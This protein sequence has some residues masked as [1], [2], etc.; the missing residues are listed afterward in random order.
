MAPINFT[1]N[2]AILFV[3]LTYSSMDLFVEWERFSLCYRPIQLW[4]IV[5]FVAIIAFR[6]SHYLG[7][8]LSDDGEEFLIY[9]QR[10]P[11]YWV[12]VLILGVLFPFFTAWTIVGT[13][14]FNQLQEHTPECLPQGSHPW[15]LMFWLVLCYI[16]IAI[17]VIFIALAM[18]Y[19][20]RARRIE[21][22]LR[23]IE[24]EDILR[25]WGRLQVLAD[26]GI[27][28]VKRGLSPT[29]IEKLPYETLDKD[30]PEQPCSICIEDFH[31]GDD[32]RLLGGCGHLFH[33]SCIDI[34]L[35]RN[36]VCP[37]CKSPIGAVGCPS[38]AIDDDL[39]EEDISTDAG[40]DEVWV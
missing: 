17:Y 20:Y 27:H 32:V 14:W 18:L 10:G 21:S 22:D 6:F 35:L 1:L 39:L 40:D 34:W 4:L 38:D 7:Q 11:P 23:I 12:N 9:N 30:P 26:Y 24:N 2:D 31:A 37:N 28:I 25:R 8:C 15:F 13:V 5:S 19:E 36:A 33:R 16:W 3:A 29:Q